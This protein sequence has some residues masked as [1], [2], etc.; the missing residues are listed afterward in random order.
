MKKQLKIAVLGGG[1]RTGKYLV[2][3]LIDRGFPVK[4]LLRKPEEFQTK[5]SLIEIFKGDATDP[6]AILRLVQD[7]QAVISTVGQRPGEPLVASKAVTNVLEAMDKYGLK[8]FISLAGLNIDTP[9]DQK[10]QQTSRATEW[11]KAN[12]PEIHAD[13]QKAYA[14]LAESTL[15]WT[16]VRVPFI[17]FMDAAGELA[18]NL[19]DC[20]SDKIKAGSLAIFLTDQLSDDT[21]IRKAPFVAN[22]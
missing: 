16:L 13:R 6:G 18:V 4:L 2:N 12:F 5:S 22:I 1:G 17:E 9:F 8:R 19:E 14:I 21:Y 15:D 10:S 3:N 20:P 7:C 11:M